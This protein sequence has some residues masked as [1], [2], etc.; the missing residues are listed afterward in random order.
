MVE[1]NA[2]QEFVNAIKEPPTDTN[3][4][5]SGIVSRVDN[6]GTVWVYLAGSD[7]ETPTA[8]TSAE[9]KKGD[10]VTVEWRN[11]KLYIAGNYSN[12][13][14]GLSRVVS[15]EMVAQVANQAAQNAVA[16]AGRASEA[17]AHAE[18][19]ASRAQDTADEVGRIADRAKQIAT[20]AQTSANSAHKSA[21]SATY[22]LSEV[23]RVVDALGWIS[24]HATYTL[25]T[26]T[27]IIDGKWYFAYNQGSYVISSPESN[28]SQE[29][30]YEL[31]NVDSA[32]SN[33]IMAHVYLDNLGLHIRM[34][35]SDGSQ[36]VLTG[37]SIYM[38]NSNSDIIAEYAGE[39]VLGDRY[40]AHIELS[41]AYGLSFYDTAKQQ[42]ESGEPLNRIA[43][44][45]Q[46]RLFIRSATLTSN[47]QIGNFRW[48]VLEHRTSLKY[49]PLS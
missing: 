23:E 43:Y 13:A 5:Y 33:Y 24:Q 6:E 35:D 44:M 31:D 28:P 8:S 12:P 47:L 20:D 46:D 21:N 1:D 16:D 18:G 34:S 38:L 25:T 10:A 36:I 15:V 17:A 27:E 4:I 11:N 45:Q 30:F 41:P 9:V 3:N 42:G 14:A 39:V 37:T 7:K 19:E 2:I 32:I 49:N 29:G 22:S 40:G 26:D 48:V